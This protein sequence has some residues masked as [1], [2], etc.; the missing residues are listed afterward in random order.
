M[1]TLV[2]REGRALIYD[3]KLLTTSQAC[4]RNMKANVH[5]LTC[6]EVICL[7]FRA[8]VRGAYYR[9]DIIVKV[10][11]SNFVNCVPL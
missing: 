10:L 4:S 3:I 11:H 5:E 7:L 8:A 2:K 9:S 1:K 6:V